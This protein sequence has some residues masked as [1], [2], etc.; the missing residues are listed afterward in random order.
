MNITSSEI[1]DIVEL[2]VKSNARSLPPED[3]EDFCQ[4][5]LVALIEE[6]GP[7]FTGC[8][9]L[10]IFSYSMT[11]LAKFRAERRARTAP[12]I[13]LDEEHSL[14]SAPLPKLDLGLDIRKA[15]DRLPTGLRNVAVDLFF[16]DLTQQEVADKYN[17]NQ[18]WVAA[19]KKQIV[20]QIYSFLKE[21]PCR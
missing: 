17:R 5:V 11:T 18:S 1:P 6:F 13:L 21:K 12:Q 15:L 20:S 10:D 4:D 9:E 14:I 19:A 16:H 7:T 2:F 8:G 3:Q